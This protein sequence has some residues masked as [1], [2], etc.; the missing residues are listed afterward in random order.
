MAIWNGAM[1]MKQRWAAVVGIALQAAAPCM[2]IHTYRYS[3][4]SDDAGEQKTTPET[5]ASSEKSK[6]EHFCLFLLSL[7]PAGHGGAAARPHRTRQR[8]GISNQRRRTGTSSRS[9][10]LHCT[11]RANRTCAASVR[12]LN[13]RT[14]CTRTVSAIAQLLRLRKRHRHGA[15]RQSPARRVMAKANDPEG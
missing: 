12:A 3:S 10:A 2:H 14:D 4:G 1:Q 5:K 7:A 9:L 6:S 13:S 11:V 8:Q 15:L